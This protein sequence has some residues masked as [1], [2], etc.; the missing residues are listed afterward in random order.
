MRRVA[1]VTVAGLSGGG[2]LVLEHVGTGGATGQPSQPAVTSA[3]DPLSKPNTSTSSP[4]Q[5]GT[6]QKNKHCIPSGV[7]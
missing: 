5:C 1:V 4:R 3:L 7:I 2:L 6:K